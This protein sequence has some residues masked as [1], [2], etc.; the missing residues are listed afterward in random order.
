MPLLFLSSSSL[1]LPLFELPEAA[2]L[3]LLLP[4]PLLELALEPEVELEPDPEL[5]CEL[6]P[7]EDD[8]PELWRTMLM[9]V[10]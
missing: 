1:P 3:P 7:E 5:F 9:I 4:E 8:E 2:D 6:L 10:V